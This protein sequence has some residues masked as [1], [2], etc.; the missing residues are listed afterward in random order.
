[1]EKEF[2][3]LGRQSFWMKNRLDRFQ[4]EKRRNSSKFD[5]K[6]IERWLSIIQERIGES[7]SNKL[8]TDMQEQLIKYDKFNFEKILQ[9]INYNDI[10]VILL[11]SQF[12]LNIFLKFLGWCFG[13]IANS[14]L[15]VM[16]FPVKAI[17]KRRKTA[18]HQKQHSSKTDSVVSKIRNLSHRSAGRKTLKSCKSLPQIEIANSQFNADSQRIDS[19]NSVDLDKLMLILTRIERLERSMVVRKRAEDSFSD[20]LGALRVIS[21][22]EPGKELAKISQEIS[23]RTILRK[24]NGEETTQDEMTLDEDIFENSECDS[25]TSCRSRSISISNSVSGQSITNSVS[26][27]YSVE[28]SCSTGVSCAISNAGGG[29]DTTV[30]KTTNYFNKFNPWQNQNI[31]SAVQNSVTNTQNNLPDGQNKVLNT[32]NNV[33]NTQNNVQHNLQNQNPTSPQHNSLKLLDSTSQCS[34]LSKS[35]NK[36]KSSSRSKNSTN[37]KKKNKNKNKGKM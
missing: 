30:I 18:D 12:I 15:V 2:E 5:M 7:V 34:V 4:I 9:H 37:K 25:D 19:M 3:K 29:G 32:Q 13:K 14:C 1:M 8:S 6:K 26:R 35:S 20:Q 16:S 17:R 27:T 10:L 28:N 21:R 24:Q 22:S 23:H 11:L 31:Q 36:S 33:L